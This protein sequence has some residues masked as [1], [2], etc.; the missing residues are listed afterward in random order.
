MES[1]H[2]HTHTPKKRKKYRNLAFPKIIFAIGDFRY[3]GKL[4]INETVPP[5]YKQFHISQYFIFRY[6]KIP[7]WCAG[8]H[9]KPLFNW[10]FT[11]YFRI[12]AD[13]E[14]NE[15]KTKNKL[16]KC[17][18]KKISYDLYK[19]KE[20][21]KQQKMYVIFLFIK[22]IFT[23]IKPTW[24]I[25]CLGRSYF[26]WYRNICSCCIYE[27]AVSQLFFRVS[28]YID[29]VLQKLHDSQKLYMYLHSTY[30]YTEFVTCVKQIVH[31][32]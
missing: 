31:R 3:Q 22:Y 27:L 24:P 26:D 21:K 8:A 18:R 25:A 9:T 28:A 20:K 4:N 30:I 19:R 29:F 5:V 15:C 17:E 13:K 14:T 11:I 2:T 7:L 10:E 32:K 6:L 16:N 12:R 1:V 23:V